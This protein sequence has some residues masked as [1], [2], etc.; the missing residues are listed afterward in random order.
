MKG[1]PERLEHIGPKKTRET[2]DIITG[3]WGIWLI[4]ALLVVF[5]IHLYLLVLSARRTISNKQDWFYF[6]HLAGLTVYY[7]V[8]ILSYCSFDFLTVLK[9]EVRYMLEAF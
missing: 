6:G 3:Y 4:L 2:R 5:S 8:L 7:V 9:C 1:S